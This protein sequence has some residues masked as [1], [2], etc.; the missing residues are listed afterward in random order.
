MEQEHG[1]REEAE[2]TEKENEEVSMTFDLDRVQLAHD[3][4]THV[5]LEII[6]PLNLDPVNASALLYLLG[7]SIRITGLTGLKEWGNT[8]DRD[9]VERM[10]EEL[11]KLCQRNVEKLKT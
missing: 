2:M 4:Y 5:V 11:E 9:A 3:T 1:A 8:E 10:A 6:R 7:T